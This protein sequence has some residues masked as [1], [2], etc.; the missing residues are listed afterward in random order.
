M[1]KRM[2]F[3]PY[4][5]PYTKANSKYIKDLNVNVKT[6]KFLEE[7]MTLVLAMVFL[8]VTPK[9]QAPKK[10][11]KSKQTLL[12]FFCG[13]KETIKRVKGN[14]R[15]GRKYF[16]IMYLI[17]AVV[18]RIYKEHL[19]LNNNRKIKQPNL[20]RSKRPEQRFFQIRHTNGQHAHKKM[21]DI[22]SH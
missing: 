12:K 13:S 22:V 1:F 8:H 6:I 20:K 5:K 11:K 21:L 2:R 18:P 9:A 15:N 10:K 7:N 3:D 17:K 19:K 14:P 16:Q 4:L